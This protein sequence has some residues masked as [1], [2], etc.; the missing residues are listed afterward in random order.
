MNERREEG[1]RELAEYLLAQVVRTPEE[2]SVELRGGSLTVSVA[3]R[4]RAIVI[5]TGGQN[6]RALEQILAEVGVTRIE[7]RD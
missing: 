1:A 3:R 6:L 7:L 4:D 2:L 5:G